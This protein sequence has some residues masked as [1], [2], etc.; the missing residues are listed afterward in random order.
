MKG[1]FLP[2]VLGV[3]LVFFVVAGYGKLENA[4]EPKSESTTQSASV[5]P[6]PTAEVTPAAT[7]TPTPIP[8]PTSAP[9][10]A[11][12]EEP[13]QSDVTYV[14]ISYSG[15]KYHS[16]PSCSGMKGPSQVTLDAAIA[17]GKEPC[18]KCY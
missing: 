2:L 7:A 4:P 12:T 9:T 5:S 14:W 6:I 10:V 1:K 18:S 15:S 17:M 13:V 8:P 11:P 3:L 16:N